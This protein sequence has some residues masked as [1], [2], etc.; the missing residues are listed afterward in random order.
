M[1]EKKEL[2]ETMGKSLQSSE[3]VST[4][5]GNESG[6]GMIKREGGEEC[7]E[8]CERC[9]SL[10]IDEKI[11]G[12]FGKRLCSKCRGEFSLI[13]QTGAAE[14]YLVSKSD[15]HFLPKMEVNNPKSTFWKPMLLYSE[16]EVK[17]I[18]ERKW[19]SIEEEKTR[20]KQ[21]LKERRSKR[22]KKKISELKKSV[23]PKIKKEEE[24]THLFD[25]E[26]RCSC[27]LE[28]EHEEI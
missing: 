20:R 23:R 7:E 10:R 21:A 1:Q 14:K 6:S 16:E 18:S 25:A 28:V 2:E 22:I 19:S 15:L 26:G 27:G 11:F 8:G 5:A 24:H 13:S 17:K 9:G 3:D 12:I 4:E